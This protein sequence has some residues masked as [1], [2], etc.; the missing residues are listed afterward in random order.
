MSD[1]AEQEVLSGA[2][3]CQKRRRKHVTQVMYARVRALSDSAHEYPQHTGTEVG[4]H[5]VPPA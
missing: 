2:A 5:G 4:V 3:G 1:K